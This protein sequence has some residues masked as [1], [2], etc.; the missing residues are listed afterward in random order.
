MK[1]KPKMQTPATVLLALLVSLATTAMTAHAAD[2]KKVPNPPAAAPAIDPATGLPVSAE[3]PWKDPNWKDPDKVLP[4]VNY[5][6]LPLTEVVLHLRQE[7]KDAFDVLIPSEWQ[8]PGNPARSIDPNAATIK[9]RLK[10]VTASE[11]FNAMN[12]VFETENAPLRWKLMMNGNRPTV[13]LRLLPQLV[14]GRPHQPSPEPPRRMIYF[15]GDLIGDQKAGGMKMAEL[16]KTI[17][18]VY[19]MS[20]GEPKGVLQFHEAAQLLIVTGTPDQIQF[21][22]QT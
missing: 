21:I 2:N 20:Y 11:V 19:Q 8:D 6:G 4:E 13:L 22:Q 1:S 5:D 15:V 16:V 9:L 12:L 10:N 7:F 14:P 18:D 3:E 17:S